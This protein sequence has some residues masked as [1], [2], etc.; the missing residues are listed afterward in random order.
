[1]SKY[2]M[3][4]LQWT[5]IPHINDIDGISRE[6]RDCLNEV[7]TVLARHQRLDKFG[8][9]LL[10]H[11]FPLDEDEILVEHCDERN[12]TLT[13]RVMPESQVDRSRMIE[14]IWR[15]DTFKGA[16]CKRM[17]PKGSDG[18]HVGYPDHS[19]AGA[20]ILPPTGATTPTAA[21]LPRGGIIE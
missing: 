6:D 12:R 18:E 3:A 16:E 2:K 14:T 5:G 20:D 11:H 9:A 4:P 21:P 1:M 8:I 7:K 15:F 19:G 17:C 13:V 10:H